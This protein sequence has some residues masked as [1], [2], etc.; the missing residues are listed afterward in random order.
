MSQALVQPPA[1]PAVLGA[2]DPGEPTG[3]A[4]AVGWIQ[5]GERSAGLERLPSH[6]GWPGIVPLRKHAL[7]VA[8]HW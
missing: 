2:N 3:Q 7:G 4:V 5:L 6:G 1:A 8:I